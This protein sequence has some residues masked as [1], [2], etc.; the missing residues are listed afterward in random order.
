MV[1]KHPFNLNLN[2][3]IWKPVICHHASNVIQVIAIV[4]VFI[5]AYCC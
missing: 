4:I 1:E 2:W 3:S 5:A